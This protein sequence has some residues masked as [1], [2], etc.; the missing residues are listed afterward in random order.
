MYDI[1]I[2]NILKFIF[3]KSYHIWVKLIINKQLHNN[4]K[5]IFLYL[6]KYKHKIINKKNK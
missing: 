2:L 4:I 6:K 3:Y 5:N 1:N